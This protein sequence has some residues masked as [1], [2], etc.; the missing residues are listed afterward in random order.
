MEATIE[1]D[2]V[3]EG[4]NGMVEGADKPENAQP[5][6]VDELVLAVWQGDVTMPKGDAKR[7]VA[8]AKK[9]KFDEDSLVMNRIMVI[10]NGD[11][12]MTFTRNNQKP[13]SKV[14]H[15]YI[16]PS[17]T[18]DV[19]ALVKQA[20]DG[21]GMCNIA[22]SGSAGCITGNT[23]IK[24]RRVGNGKTPIVKVIDK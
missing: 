10:D 4:A 12:T 17:F 15:R 16:M 20:L 19:H 3:M 18:D 5:A 23:K 1:K 21:E 13:E 9:V 11:G 6:T 24:V 22:M 14:S 2:E 8:E 7:L